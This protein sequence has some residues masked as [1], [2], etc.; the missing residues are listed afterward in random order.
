[1]DNFELIVLSIK[2]KFQGEIVTE[3]PCKG[4]PEKN[5]SETI[6]EG[7]KPVNPHPVGGKLKIINRR[8]NNDLNWHD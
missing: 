2:S 1:M 6:W 8:V 5:A 4:T 3:Y 7:S